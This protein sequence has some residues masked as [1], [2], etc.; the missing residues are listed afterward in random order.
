MDSMDKKSVT[1]WK[2]LFGEDF[3]E[4]PDIN[5]PENSARVNAEIR[6]KVQQFKQFAEGVGKPLFDQLQ[7]DLRSGLFTLMISSHKCD[8]NCNLSILTRELQG[9]LKLIAKANEV[10]S[11]N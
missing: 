10:I 3:E 11:K 8:C 9:I 6:K 1:A 2:M 4:L 7:T 5:K